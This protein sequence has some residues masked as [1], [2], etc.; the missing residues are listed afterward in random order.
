MLHHD[1]LAGDALGARQ[2][3]VV[4]VQLVHH[5]AAQPHRVIRR[6]AQGHGEHRQNPGDRIGLVKEHGNAQK[7][8]A[9]ELDEDVIHRRRHRVDEDDVD[10]AE[11]VPEA[12]LSLGHGRAQRDAQH[13]RERH[14]EHAHFDGQRR[15]LGDDAGDGRAHAVAGG[16]AQIPVH[17]ALQEVPKLYRDGIVEAQLVELGLDHRLVRLLKIIKIAL[18]RHLAQQNKDHR[19]DDQ[20]RQKRGGQPLQ[21][22]FQHALFTT[23]FIFA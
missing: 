2:A 9:V 23:F 16:G 4:L 19:N 22:V 14:G 6:I 13:Q 15:L 21:G 7:A 8:G 18:D 20:Q 17:Q 1:A 3:D 5:V 10:R 11:L 12:S